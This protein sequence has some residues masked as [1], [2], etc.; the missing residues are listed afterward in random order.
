MKY[1]GAHVSAEGGVPNA[2]DHA[3]KLNANAFG[4]FLKNQK[5]WVSPSYTASTIEDFKQKLSKS[6]IQPEHVLPHNSYLVNPGNP[7]D[8]AWTKS[9]NALIDELSRAEQLGLKNLNIHPG[10]HLSGLSEEECLSRI[11]HAINLAHEK[12]VSAIVLI[13]NTA[14]QGTNVGYRFEHLASII[15]QVKNK[16]R[17]GVCLDTCHAFV[18]GYDL[19]GAEY[20]QTMEKFEK[21]VGFQWLKG[22]HLNDSLTEYASR[23]DRHQSLGKGHLGWGVFERIMND[24]R[25]DGIPLILET[26]DENLW[27]EE[28]RKLREL[29]S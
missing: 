14:G 15:R 16:E 22:V 20:D 3:L 5:R 13:E 27:E 28:I 1:I 18:S 17:I 19:R 2:V 12:T 25:F 24:Q 8:E 11:A 29:I 9:V 23:K 21:A 10:A 7:D 26:I 4:L 6:G